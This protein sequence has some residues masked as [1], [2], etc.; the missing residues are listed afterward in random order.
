M[1]WWETNKKEIFTEKET[2]NNILSL[3]DSSNIE[4]LIEY[5]K[6]IYDN[7]HNNSL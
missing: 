3:K 5:I 1:K 2:S 7:I 4:Y 6:K